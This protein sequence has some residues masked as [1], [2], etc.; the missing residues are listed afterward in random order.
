MHRKPRIGARARIGSLVAAERHVADRQVEPVLGQRCLFEGFEAN[1]DAARGVQRLQQPPRHA[2][3]LDGADRAARRQVAGHRADEVA[4]AGRRFQHAPA[5]EAEAL[6]GLPDSLDHVDLG[7]V[8]VVDRGAGG[9]M[10]LR[11]QQ[12]RQAL[13]ARAPGRVLA[14]QVEGGGNAAPAAEAQQRVALVGR[15]GTSLGLQPLQQHDRCH[16]A[17][18]LGGCAAQPGQMR[19]RDG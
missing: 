4:D 9:G 16:V 3:D 1:V 17:V 7:V 5:V 18:E 2:V 8:A 14:F 12:C 11:A 6:H 13:C 19:A 10:V 15:R